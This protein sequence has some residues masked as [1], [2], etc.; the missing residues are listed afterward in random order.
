MS[1]LL[2]SVEPSIL[3]AVTGGTTTTA[4]KTATTTTTTGSRSTSNDQLLQTLTSLSNTIKD[5]GNAANK[6][7]FS[8][9]DILMLGILMSQNRQVNVFVR[10]PFW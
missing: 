9:T 2:T 8:T 6:S 7:G 5:I 3:E 1:N 10:R 4:T